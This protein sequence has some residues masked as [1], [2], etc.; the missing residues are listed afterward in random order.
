VS[1]I[2]LLARVL[3]DARHGSRVTSDTP[4]GGAIA[5]VEGS[6]FCPTYG[7]FGRMGNALTRSNHGTSPVVV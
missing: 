7:G 4:G 6:V 2:G 1:I 5:P 3:H